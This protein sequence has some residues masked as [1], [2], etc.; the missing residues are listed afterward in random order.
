M[1]EL[2]LI[3][4]IIVIFVMWFSH[5]KENLE[6]IKSDSMS[7]ETSIDSEIRDT[8]TQ[9]EKDALRYAKLIFG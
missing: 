4:I 2:F 8:I 9:Q 5:T 1:N 6:N 3:I 7:E